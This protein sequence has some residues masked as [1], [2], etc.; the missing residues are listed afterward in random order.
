MPRL[1]P[2]IKIAAGVLLFLSL[3]HILFFLVGAKIVQGGF[4]QE[5]PYTYLSLAMCFI[6]GGGAAGVIVSVGLFLAR[7]W[8]R[9]AAIAVA[10]IVAAFSCLGILLELILMVRPPQIEGFEIRFEG[11]GALYLVLIYLLIFSI[12]IWWLFLFSR[13]TVAAQFSAPGGANIPSTLTKPAC[14]PPIAL[15]AW[16]MMATSLLCAISWPILLGKIPAMLFTR[17]Y[18]HPAS[19]WIWAINLL[20]LAASGVGLLLLK[21]WSYT[22]AI[23]LHLFW[24][25]SI[26]V[27]QLSSSYASYIR[28][29][30]SQ[31]ELPEPLGASTLSFLPPWLSAIAT[32]LPTALLIAGLFYYRPSF[33]AAAAARN[34]TKLPS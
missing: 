4:P 33:L 30:I 9:I 20:L 2:A 10:A 31:L 1:T 14:P 8:A 5:P 27:S 26:F 17:V 13:K 23:T 3:L 11:H 34:T 7:N 25:I 6:A 16:L 12:A 24:M 28:E 18:H 15:L 22:A 19:S 32:A 29:C 21:R